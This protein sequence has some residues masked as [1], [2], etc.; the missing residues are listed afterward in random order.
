[1]CSIREML[2]EK[3][4][5][6]N[7]FFTTH[8]YPLFLKFR[9]RQRSFVQFPAGTWSIYK[10]LHETFS[11]SNEW[12]GTTPPPRPPLPGRSSIDRFKSESG[13]IRRHEFLQEWGSC[14][15]PFVCF[16]TMVDVLPDFSVEFVIN[17]FF[18]EDYGA[19]CSFPLLNFFCYRCFLVSLQDCKECMHSLKYE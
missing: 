8:R 19:L 16:Y 13:I 15:I 5:N 10:H 9:Q 3:L 6:C 2:T 1:M 7:G 4:Q 11:N 17:Y 12:H 18:P 14:I